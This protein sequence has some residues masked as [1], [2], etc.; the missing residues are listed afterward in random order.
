MTSAE[1]NL[2]LLEAFPEIT[3]AYIEETSW[4]DGNETG[5]HVVYADVF[6]PFIKEQLSNGNEHKLTEI[7]GYIEKLLNLNDEYV[8]EVV[9]FS[10]I[11][12]LLYDEDINIDLFIKHAKTGTSNLIKEVSESIG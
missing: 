5:S 2:K 3:D 10:V 8:N 12:S 11:E 9:A 1:L 7:C 6:V 4:Q